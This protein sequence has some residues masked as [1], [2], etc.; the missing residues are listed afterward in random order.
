[1]HDALNDAGLQIHQVG[2]INDH[3][4]STLLG[5]RVEYCAI[6][7][8]LNGHSLEN[9]LSLIQNHRLDV[10]SVQQEQLKQF[11]RFYLYKMTLFQPL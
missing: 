5:D 6:E 11:S 2:Y 1:M 4:T 3:N 8:L 7:R 10:Y 9:V